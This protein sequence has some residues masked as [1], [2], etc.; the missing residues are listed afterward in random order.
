LIGAVVVDDSDELMIINDNGVLIR[1]RVED[2]SVSGRITS[3]VRLMRVDENTKL[4]SLAKI[5]D[6]ES[7][8]E[9]NEEIE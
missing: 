3:G 5:H 7:E 4:V 2:I 9:K 6:S 1:I 8:E